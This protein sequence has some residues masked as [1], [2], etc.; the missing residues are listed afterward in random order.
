MKCQ[1]ITNVEEIFAETSGVRLMTELFRPLYSPTFVNCSSS[2]YFG[3]F[4]QSKGKEYSQTDN[5]YKGEI[6]PKHNEGRIF[7]LWSTGALLTDQIRRLSSYFGQIVEFVRAEFRTRLRIL[8]VRRVSCNLFFESV[9]M[10]FM[11]A[12]TNNGIGICLDN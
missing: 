11:F 8:L 6:V 1:Q 4:I 10:P 12:R 2:S 7:W 9:M 3:N 5:R